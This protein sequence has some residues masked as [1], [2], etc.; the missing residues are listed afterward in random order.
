VQ[1]PISPD[2][3]QQQ[4]RKAV[5]FLSAWPGVQRIW[6]FGSAAKG[7][8]LDWRSDLDFAVEGLPE[9]DQYCAWSELDSSMDMPV[10]LIL[11][12]KANPTLREEIV[13]WGR[14]VYEA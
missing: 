12:E 1:S 8:R 2:V 14:M 11:L 5:D 4:I 9:D 13:K 10:D 6:L 3:I 7:R